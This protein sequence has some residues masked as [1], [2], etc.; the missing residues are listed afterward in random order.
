MS[1]YSTLESRYLLTIPDKGRD[2]VDKGAKVFFNICTIPTVTS[3]VCIEKPTYFSKERERE[4][5][6]KI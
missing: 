4:S 1:T 3:T 6:K 2:P 5:E